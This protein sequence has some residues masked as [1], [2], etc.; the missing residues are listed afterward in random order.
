VRNKKYRPFSLD[1]NGIWFRTKYGFSIYSNMKDRILELDKNPQWEKTESNFITKN[2]KKGD[3]FIDVGANIGYFSLLAST[4]DPAKILAVEPLPH[5][6]NMLNMNIEYNNLQD[7]I[8]TCNIGLASQP[9]TAEFTSSLG[10]KNHIK[11]KTNNIHEKEP[12]VRI[13][14][15]TLDNILNSSNSITKV[16]LIKVD[17][18]GAEYDFLL[19][20]ENTISKHKPVIMMEIEQHRLTKFN[21]TAEQIFS[22]MNNLGYTYLS[23]SQETISPG[24]DYKTE[25][26]FARDFIF[27]TQDHNL[28]Y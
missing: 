14:L 26:K 18:E 9:G 21:N 16:D 4:C 23:V 24:K 1:E 13:E 11:Y 8:Q 20:A 25:M 6:F 27:Y 22:F 15:D 19:G 17:I 5:T 3:V 10:P 12:T 28:I 2:L 7:K